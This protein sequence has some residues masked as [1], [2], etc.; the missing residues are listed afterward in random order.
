MENPCRDLPDPE[1]SPT[2]EDPNN[3]LVGFEFQA[4][5]VNW[6]VVGTAGWS[7]G[8]YVTIE[9]DFSKFSFSPLRP[10]KRSARPAGLVRQ[11]KLLT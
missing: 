1:L 4:E 11:A 5:G 9:E 6:R 7:E 8:N 10:P 2:R 3:D